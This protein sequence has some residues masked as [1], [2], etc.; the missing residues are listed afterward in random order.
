LIRR[1]LQANHIQER[2]FVKQSMTGVCLV[3]VTPDGERSMVTFGGDDSEV[4][5]TA[6]PTKD[7]DNAKLLYT[8]GY[9]CNDPNR[10][11]LFSHCVT[12]AHR[13][14]TAIAFDLADP[15]VVAEHKSRIQTFIDK[16]MIDVLFGN[17]LE[18]EELFGKDYLTNPSLS[19][20]KVPIIVVKLGA[21]GALII[22]KNGTYKVAAPHCDEVVDTTGAGDMFAAGFIHGLLQGYPIEICGEIGSLLA[23][24]VIGHMGVELSDDIL[25]QTGQ[26]LSSHGM[27]SSPEPLDRNT[28]IDDVRAKYFA[29]QHHRSPHRPARI[30]IAGIKSE[31]EA[32]MLLASGVDVIGFPL[33]LP[34]HKADTTEA[35]AADIIEGQQASENALLITYL[36]NS[37]TVHSLARKLSTK[38]IQLHGDISVTEIE[39]LK[40]QDESYFVIKSL[41]VHPDDNMADLERMIAEYGDC[42]D[43]FIIDTYDPQTGACGA[44]G[45]TQDW[46]ISRKLVELSPKPIILAGGLNPDNVYGAIMMVKPAAVDV[47]TGVESDDGDKDPEL[48]R[49]FVEEAKRGFGEG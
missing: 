26:L 34:V 12:T 24:D 33:A 17:V 6:L 47:H 14:G 39:K 16:G 5:V 3:L 28:W 21:K 29:D 37:E 42:V 32:R 11:R 41:V 1:N 35:G 4:G 7:I 18:I 43:A 15:K 25:R 9:M 2:L 31:A 30:Q 27:M 10:F 23:G 44:T 38:N 22:T 20:Q 48:V 49:R 13:V 8:S 19:Q 46:E 45:K 40:A 36:D